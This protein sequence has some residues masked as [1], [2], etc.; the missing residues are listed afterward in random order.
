MDLK[1]SKTL[2]ISYV[3]IIFYTILL[4][5]LQVA[6]HASATFAVFSPGQRQALILEGGARHRAG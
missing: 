1:K 2:Q 5:R 3:R 4:D 6:D